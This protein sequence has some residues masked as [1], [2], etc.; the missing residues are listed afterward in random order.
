MPKVKWCATKEDRLKE[1]VNTT[2][3]VFLDALNGDRGARD[4]DKK[5]YAQKVIDKNE[6]TLTN[7]TRSNLEGVPINE[8]FRAAILAGYKINLV[9]TKE[10]MTYGNV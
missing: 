7:W 10:G 9:L 1:K 3:K 2:T 4:M 8:V 6:R 5:T